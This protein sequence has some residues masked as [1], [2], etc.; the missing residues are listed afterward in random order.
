M[1]LWTAPGPELF[2]VYAYLA[3]W[4]FCWVLNVPVE[5]VPT[6]RKVDARISV[7]VTVSP[8]QS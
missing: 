8:A 5:R 4:W 1:C 2:R 3:S 7:E 6:A